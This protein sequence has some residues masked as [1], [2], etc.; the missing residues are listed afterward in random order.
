M[1]PSN[2]LVEGMDIKEVI[3]KLIIAARTEEGDILL[4][5]EFAD[6]IIECLKEHVNEPV[7]K[8]YSRLQ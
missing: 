7:I 8:V 3:V 4:D 5:G 2:H 1:R 6:D